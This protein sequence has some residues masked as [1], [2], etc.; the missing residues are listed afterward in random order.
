MKRLNCCVAG[1]GG[2]AAC[3]VEALREIEGVRLRTLVGRR[4]EPAEE[5]GARHGFDRVTTSYEEALAD[6][7]LDAIVLATPSETHHDMTTR[8][9]HAGKDV[10]V[11]IPLA[12]SRRGA[13]ELVELERRTGRR[14]MVAHTRRFGPLGRFVRDFLAS[15]KAGRVHQ[16]HTYAFWLRHENVG[17]TGYRRSWVD[18]VLFH[19]A[20]HH[21]D[22][23]LW[24]VGDAVRRVRGE[25][26]TL[27]P[28]TGTSLDVSLLIR[29]E[30]ECLTTVSLSYNARQGAG[31]DTYICENGCLV[32]SGDRVTFGGEVLLE[33]RDNLREGI[34]AQDREFVDAIREDRPPSCGV[35]EGLRALTVLQEVHDQMTALEGESRYRRMW[36]L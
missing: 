17:W 22:F 8:A 18:D 1:Y 3:H 33:A 14:I 29:H 28:R 19:H 2:I 31:G 11:E 13:S 10:L 4:R 20:C 23:A 6:P 25:L 12:M 15:G 36:G 24:T 32:L 7:D 5:F 16:Y 21:V 26:S 9:L 34:R 30:T 27:D 35:G